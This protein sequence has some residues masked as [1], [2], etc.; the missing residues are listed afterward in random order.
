[1]STRQKLYM[2]LPLA[3]ILCFMLGCQDKAEWRG[4]FEEE[5]GVMVV[6]NPQEP[7]YGPE[8]FNLEED[9]IITNEAGEEEYMFQ[10]IQNLAVDDD[11]NIYVS[12]MKAA[13]IRVFD[14]NGEY[15]RTI[16]KQGQGPGEMLAPIDIKALSRGVLIINDYAQLRL[17]FF[18]LN[19]EHIR[20]LSTHKYTAFRRPAIDSQG[21]IVAGFVIPEDE[22]KYE[23]TK[24]DSDLNPVF[25]VTTYPMLTIF[26]ST[27]FHYFEQRRSTNLVWNVNEQDQIIWGHMSKYEL[28]VHNPDGKLMKKIIRDYDGIEI[29]NQEKEKLIKDFLGDTPVPSNVN[30]IFPDVYPPFI[31]FSCDEEGR[32]YVQTYDK[33]EDGEADYYDVFDSG[34]KYIARFSLKYWAIVWKKQ[35]LYTIEEDDDGFQVVK[36][37]KVIWKI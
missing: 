15:V 20:N 34:G 23:L 28:F 22:V 1:M 32:I 9:L 33:T 10:D 31:R 11:E 16:G 8:V 2:I 27:N 17:N 19:G 30:I 35:K 12:D 3:L 36:R 14:K 25:T 5:D 24:F 29:T 37:Y 21:N 6:K 18:S 13:Y 4:T 7:I 26:G